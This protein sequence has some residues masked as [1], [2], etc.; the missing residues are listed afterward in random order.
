M[1][2]RLA[3]LLVLVAQ[4]AAADPPSALWDDVAHPNRLRCAKLVEEGRTLGLAHEGRRGTDTRGPDT[5]RVLAVLSEATRLCP[6]HFEALSLY[7]VALTRWADPVTARTVLERARQLSPAGDD[8]DAALAFHL[9]FTRAVTGEL[10][11][12]LVEYRRAEALTPA[13]DSWL[14]Y[15]D[16][17]DTLMALGRLSEAIES[18][19]RATR[20]RASEPMP[21]FALAVALDRDGQVER[22]RVALS[23][24]LARDPYL[25]ILRSDRFVFLP[26]SDRQYYLAL[27]HRAQ[28]RPADAR[29][30][31]E[32]FMSEVPDSPY[33]FRAREVLGSLN[34]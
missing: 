33:V 7:G 8:K 30:A 16:L 10:E 5:E 18:Y 2:V 32:R 23:A 12:S 1:R 29:A 11:G 24:G 17:G 3:V 31:L 25:K 15:Y 28:G 19:R 22:A 9:A 6:R 13:A 27:C 4:V 34:K 21:H 14:L 26:P 20:A